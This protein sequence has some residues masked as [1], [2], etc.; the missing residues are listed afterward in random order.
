MFTQLS[1]YLCTKAVFTAAD[2]K[3]VQKKCSYLTLQPGQKLLQRG[4]VWNYHAFICNGL[5]RGYKQDLSGEE[6]TVLFAPEGYWTGDRESLLTGAPSLLEIVAETYC[7][8]ILI[9]QDDYN[10]LCVTVSPFAEFMSTLV[11]RN[12]EARR[13]QIINHVIS[14]EEK[15][16]NFRL[17]FSTVPGRT[18]PENI[19]SL[20]EMD[21]KT[22]KTLL[23][24]DS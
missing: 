15:V 17:K 5:A 3:A 12:L 7:E 23:L 9:T 19:A 4:T 11:Q 20:L 10:N 1:N 6:Q 21:V 22:L 14:D 16:K 13:A 24:K 8:I 18:A 2:L